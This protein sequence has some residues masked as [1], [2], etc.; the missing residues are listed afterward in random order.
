MAV[1]SLSLVCSI[2]YTLEFRTEP[3]H[4]GDKLILEHITK[5]VHL[6]EVAVVASENVP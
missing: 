3:V 5:L 2:T 6:Q 4:G 1:M